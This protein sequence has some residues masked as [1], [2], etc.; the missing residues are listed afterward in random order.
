MLATALRSGRAARRTQLARL[1]D[2]LTRALPLWV[3]TLG[4][5]EDLLRPTP[6]LFDVVILDEASAIDQPLAD[7]ALLRARRAVVV[8]D[9]HQLRHVSFLADEKLRN[10]AEDHR[11]A[12]PLLVGRLDVRRNSLFDVAAGVAPATVLDE[13]FRSSPH[14][15]GFVARRLYGGRLH[16]ATRSPSTEGRDCIDVVRMAG[17]RDQRASS[18]S[19]STPCSSAWKSSCGGGWP[20]S[21][22]SAPSG[23]RRTRWRAPSSGLS[24]C[25]TSKPS[26]SEWAPSR[27]PGQRERRRGRLHGDRRG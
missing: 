4:D 9:P 23:L 10:V 17:R 21:V 22:C 27:L 8:G 26:I 20:A 12:D 24:R 7:P 5:V 15:I 16:V 14:L 1:D 3:G 19:R 13:H 11:I 6:A 18:A 25:T 2:R